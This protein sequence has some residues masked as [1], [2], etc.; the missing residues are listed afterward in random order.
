MHDSGALFSVGSQERTHL[1][2]PHFAFH[3][4]HTCQELGQELLLSCTKTLLARKLLTRK[5]VMEA[6]KK[7]QL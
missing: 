3:P 5:T 2:L 4:K 1:C 7:V 6:V